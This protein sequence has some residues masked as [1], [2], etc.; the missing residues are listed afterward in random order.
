MKGEMPVARYMFFLLVA[1]IFP[2]STQ[3][4]IEMSSPFTLSKSVCLDNV[5]GSQSQRLS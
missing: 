4:R 5:I 2:K 3:G 1:Q